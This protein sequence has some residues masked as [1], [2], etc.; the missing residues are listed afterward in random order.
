M[1]GL[2]EKT[3]SARK[4][5][6]VHRSLRKVKWRAR[7]ERKVFPHAIGRARQGCMFGHA[8]GTRTWLPKGAVTSQ[9]KGLSASD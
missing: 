2:N 4:K 5:E 8:V 3:G 9:A 1:W 6:V 7:L